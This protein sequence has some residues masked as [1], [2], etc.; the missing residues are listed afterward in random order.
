MKD[1][2]SAEESDIR[3]YSLTKVKNKR[4]L[5][6]FDK[7]MIYYPISVLMNAGIDICF[8]QDNWAR[9]TKCLFYS[10]HFQKQYSLCIGLC[11]GRWY[12]T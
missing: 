4:L 11:V 5:P 12:G 3:L 2:T 1:I 6:I 10:L 7:P 8:V 9:T